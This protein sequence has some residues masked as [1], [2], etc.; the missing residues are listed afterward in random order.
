M[1]TTL[2][3]II[4]SGLLNFWR[5]GW[6][7]TATVLIM[8]IALITWTSIF[9]LNVVL[10]SVLDVLAEKVDVSV[11]FNL[12]TKE[13]DIL[14]LKSKLESLKEVANVDYVSTDQALEIFKNRHANDD[15][16]LKS[17]QELNNNPLEASL[18]ILAKDSSDYETIANFLNTF[19]AKG[20]SA[21]GGKSIISKINYTENKVVIDRLNNIIRVLRKSGFA[22]GLILAF[23][24][25]LVAFNTVR[26]AIYSSREEIT[27][28]KLVG[29]SNWFVRGP[30]IVEGVL[31]GMIA[32]AFSFMVIIP[33]IGFLG[34]KLF[35]FLPEMNL[36][37]Y[38]G[39]NFWPLLFFQTLGGII[40]GVFSSWVAIRKYLRV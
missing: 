1:F 33:G 40:L 6:L 26:L 36:M 17:I 32:S 25:F 16:L 18:N 12:G 14:A 10:T 22:A 28:M 13:P 35:N 9:L 34:P 19:S 15:V 21:S 5:N 37:N 29:A 7:S 8:T 24:A 20:E 30:F 4:K 3:R 38:V 2:G 23:I 39:N 27:V 31:H 11:Y